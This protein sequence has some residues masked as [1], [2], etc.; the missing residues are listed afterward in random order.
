MASSY[1]QL[2]CTVI[3]INE[4]YRLIF[5]WGTRALIKLGRCVHKGSGVKPTGISLNTKLWTLY[6]VQ[7][8]TQICKYF[9]HLYTHVYRLWGQGATTS[10]C[11]SHIVAIGNTMGQTDRWM[12][13]GVK[14]HW[15]MGHT[16]HYNYCWR[17]W[18]E[19]IHVQYKLCTCERVC[20]CTYIWV[21]RV[22]KQSWHS[23]W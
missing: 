3:V 15:H 1:V 13:G 21:G 10:Y 23:L 20:P 18:Q 7:S 5:K 2:P 17:A 4:W 14:S 11:N 6:I 22:H 12:S 16:L 8:L 9:R 19:H